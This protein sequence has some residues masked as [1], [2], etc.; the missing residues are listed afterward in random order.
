MTSN[1]EGL[2]RDHAEQRLTILAAIDE[3]LRRHAEVLPLIVGAA[4]RAAARTAIG[5]LLRIEETAATA[6]LALQ[7]SDLTQA[8]RAVIAAERA[9]LEASLAA[10]GPS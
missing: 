2:R 5:A 1:D 6:V 10:P 3:A 4:D 7:W 9:Q 8:R